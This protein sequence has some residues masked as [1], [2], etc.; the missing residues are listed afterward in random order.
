MVVRTWQTLSQQPTPAPF[1]LPVAS[2]A[3]LV[4]GAVASAT[5]GALDGNGVLALAVV[6]VALTALTAQPVATPVIAVI[7]WMTSAAFSRPP[8]AELQLSGGRP[9]REAVVLGTTAVVSLV[10]T[11]ALRRLAATLDHRQRARRVVAAAETIAATAAG[12]GS[13]LEGV[14]TSAPSVSHRIG[15]LVTAVEAPRR[16][17]GF[18]TA[19]ILLP[20]ITLGLIALR[21][22]LSLADDLLIY[23]VALVAITVIGGF[24]P[25]VASAVAS[26]LLLN[27]YFTPPLHTWSIDRPENVLALLLFVTVALAVGSVVHLSAQRAAQAMRA[28]VESEAL[29]EL[30]RTVLD[31]QD[32]P[33]RVLAHLKDTLGVAAELQEDLGTGWVTIAGAGNVAPGD[34]AHVVAI[35]AD[36]R[37]RLG[38]VPAQGGRVLQ[39]YAAQVAAALDRERLRTQAAQAEALAEGNR[40]RTALL[41]AVSHDLRTPLASIKASVTSLRQRDVVW[42]EQDQ[43]ALLATIEESTD[44]LDGLIG[45]LLDM[46]RLQTGALQPFLRAIALDEVVPLALRGLEGAEQVELE[47][48]DSLPL[49]ATDP[50][51]LERALANL[52]S[53]ALRYS[54]ADRPPAVH[55]CEEEGR[56]VLA[57]VDH[58]PGVPAASRERIFE[59]FQRL[60]DR[61]TGV[62]LG[63]AVAR[64]FLEAMGGAISAED[65]PGGGLTMRVV[66]PTPVAAE[67]EADVQVSP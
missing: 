62:G 38:G 48:P 41:A 10:V 40:M 66:L 23:L 7:A 57:V 54:P 33:N 39:G 18:V 60:G 32:S 30:A 17:A 51:L 16:L 29:L 42:S 61:G 1:A 35:R 37:L 34:D 2:T 4:I 49:V 45:N 52:V 3:L 9:V 11:V 28:G 5:H 12:A 46:S 63:L 43:A 25:A 67:P 6:V 36:L 14:G 65:S 64:G 47:L 50:G 26:S 59:P 8:Y 20:L 58:G 27:W 13:T 19:A 56:V 55:A 21:S 24:W 31:G 44:R 15:D 22:H 53:N